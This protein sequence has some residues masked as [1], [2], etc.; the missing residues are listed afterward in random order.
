[1][2]V[3][4]I[5]IGSNKGDSRAIIERAIALIE[6]QSGYKVTRSRYITTP[7]WGYDSPNEFLNI[8]ISMPTSLTP[9][10]LLDTLLSIQHRISP[11]SHR[12][13]D[14]TYIDRLIDIDLIAVDDRIINTPGRTLPHPRMHLRKFVLIPMLEI[15]PRWKH[16]IL[17]KSIAELIADI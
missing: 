14:G 5:N 4:Y 7:P 13:A 1:M 11:D 2:P 9:Q 3:A 16:P 6:F 8:G 12:G 15:A 10:E 17:N